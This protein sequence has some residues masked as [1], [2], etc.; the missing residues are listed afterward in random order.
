MAKKGVYKITG[1]TH[2]KTGEKTVYTV[3]EWYPDTP[4]SD[5]RDVLVT[6]ELFKK[7]D[8]GQFV[9]THLK[10]KGV[11]EF[12]FGEQAYQSTFRVEGYLH[13]PEGKEPMAIIVHPQK[14]DGPT[15][16]EKDILGVRLTYQDGS[17]ITKSLSYMD[18]LHATVKCQNLEGHYITLSLWEDDEK[19]EG[20][21]K[22]N[23]FITK[24]PPIHVDSKGYARWN[25]TLLSTYISIA[26]KR[27]D[28]KKQHEYY[29]LA[30]YNGKLQASDNVNVNNPEYKIPPPPSKPTHAKKPQPKPDTPKGSTHQSSRNNQP[31]KKGIIKKITLVDKDGKP[32]KRRPTFGQTIKLIIEAENVVGKKYNL[33]LWEHDSWGGDDLLYNNTH[34]FKADRQKILIPLTDEMQT[35][36]EI[37]I[38]PNNP[39]YGEYW[40]GNWQEIYAEVTL[41]YISTKSPIINVD[42]EEKPKVLDNGRSPWKK[43]KSEVVKEENECYCKNNQFY[44]GNKLTCEERKKVLQICSELWGEKNKIQKASELMSVIHLETNKTFSPSAD[45]G[46]GYTG[47]IQFNDTSAKSV[48]SSR[49][50]L[51]KNDL[52]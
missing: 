25:F 10:K 41:L 39:N 15:S 9:T 7:N 14:N 36:G 33:K 17:T 51:K 28:D 48:G 8:K 38:D 3:T 20:H 22:K 24:S 6:W 31:D 2:P 40:T 37:G 43:E 1:N 35:I 50:E 44:W 42:I 26:N 32:F 46:A 21:H 12:T 27:E 11:G 4:N 52:Q 34:T 19:H 47:L 13:S 5:R 23:Q 45:N 30:E 18:R 49:S 29:I 16:K